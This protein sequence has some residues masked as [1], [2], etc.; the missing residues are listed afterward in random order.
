VKLARKLGVDEPVPGPEAA[1]IVLLHEGHEMRVGD[2][3]R[4]MLETGIVKL[5]GKTPVQTISAYLAKA[6]KKGD[7]FV[8]VDAATYDLKER[9][10]PAKAKAAA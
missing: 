1:R 8:R 5:S 3:S 10:K 6:A 2:I 7:T 9:D 4:M